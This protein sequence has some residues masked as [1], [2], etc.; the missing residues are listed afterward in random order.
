MKE[1]QI[2]HIPCEI[3]G[4][5]TADPAV[6]ITIDRTPTVDEPV[7]LQAPRANVLVDG[8]PMPQEGEPFRGRISARIVRQIGDVYY[9]QMEVDQGKPEYTFI[10]AE[11]NSNKS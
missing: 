2:I 11:D 10:S 4:I 3:R 5:D 1:G 8:Q 7:S 9:V 6:L